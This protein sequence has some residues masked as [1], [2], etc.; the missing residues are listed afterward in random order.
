MKILEIKILNF[1]NLKNVELNFSSG[2]N[3][4]HGENAQGKT[5]FIEA[6]WMF[7]GA[8]SFRG[9]K[10]ADVVNFDQ[11]YARL[12]GK[13]EFQNR[14]HEIAIFF[15]N[16]K[17][18][19]MLDGVMKPYPTSIIGKFRAVLF[20]PVNLSLVKDGPDYRRKFIDAAICQLKPT[21]TAYI[22]GYNQIL[23]QRNAFLKSDNPDVDLLEVWDE[24]ISNIGAVVLCERLKYL[25]FLKESCGL[26]YDEISQ[27]NEQLSLKYV[28]TISKKIDEKITV[29]SV[30]ELFIE[31]L[32]KFRTSD[33]KSKITSVGPH[34][35]DMEFMINGKFVRSFGSQGQ[36]RSV[37][38]TLKLAEADILKKFIGEPPV[39]LL[40]DVMSELDENRRFYLVKKTADLQVFITS[41]EKINDYNFSHIKFFKAENGKIF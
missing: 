26:I 16:G 4:I 24:K 17:R 10:D 15:E 20:S 12:D 27:K 2:V 18:N 36:Q 40:D 25:K 13:I 9:A 11:G 30:R 33:I 37:A 7:T 14:E 39:V 8:R 41:C 3:F 21:F 19:V 35:D 1:R 5:N 34:K 22:A 31:R 6:I 28:S 29:D 32:K 38:L 23:R